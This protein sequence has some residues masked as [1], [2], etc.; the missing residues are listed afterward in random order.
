MVGYRPGDFGPG[1]TLFLPHPQ[2]HRQRN[3]QREIKSTK[4]QGYYDYHP[5][6]TLERPLVLAGPIGGPQRQVAHGLSARLG[7]PFVELDRWI[8]HDAGASLWEILAEGGEE[9]LRQW[10]TDALARALR[11][12]PAGI[13]VL[14]PTALL[15]SDNLPAVLQGA[16]LVALRIDLPNLY[17]FL[18]G[19]EQDGGPQRHPFL[20]HP[21]DSI[22]ALRPLYETQQT[23]LAEAH[24]T[25][26]AVGKHPTRLTEE[27]LVELPVLSA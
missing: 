19:R 20:P 13:V 27:L 9:P 3:P 21:L 4:M 5:L 10:E 2:S 16:T 22:D 12:R 11:A 14:G 23:A 6:R 15:H 18:R 25:I 17:W 7:L 26:D 8:E 24:H 1:N